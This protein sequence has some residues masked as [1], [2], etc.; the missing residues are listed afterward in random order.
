M[1]AKSRFLPFFGFLHNF[2][3]LG[4]IKTVLHISKA[5]FQQRNTALVTNNKQKEIIKKTD[6]ENSI[7]NI[8]IPKRYAKIFHIIL[9][10][11]RLVVL[12][13]HPSR[14]RTRPEHSKASGRAEY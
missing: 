2:G 11:C 1:W 4:K 5:A 8:L 7:A 12:V 6:L 10:R 13:S 3:K 9:K 14:T